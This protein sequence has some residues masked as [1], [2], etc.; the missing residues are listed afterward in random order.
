[1]NNNL[2][3]NSGKETWNA[4]N[5]PQVIEIETGTVG[6]SEFSTFCGPPSS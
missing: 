2:K 6:G 5:I 4:P 3:N 1:M